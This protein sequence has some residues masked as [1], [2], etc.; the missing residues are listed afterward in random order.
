MRKCFNLVIIASTISG[1]LAS[2][3]IA[4]P[5]YTLNRA[6]ERNRCG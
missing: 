3:Q 5:D 1:G 4:G 2:F 6:F